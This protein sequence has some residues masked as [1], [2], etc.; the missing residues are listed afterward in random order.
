M[1]R[2][3]LFV[4]LA[5]S[6]AANAWLLLR[7][8]RPATAPAVVRSAAAPQPATPAA[9]TSIAPPLA[10]SG[11][12]PATEAELGDL[13]RQLESLGL[14]REVVQAAVA[15][16]LQRSFQKRRAEILGN[17]G[18]DEYWRNPVQPHDPAV[19]AALRDLEREQ[20]R[21]FRAL[22]GNELEF[23]ET[24]AKRQFG[25]LAPAKVEQLK[26]IFADYAD[27]EE[28][29]FT[30]VPDRNAASVRA[31]SDLLARE[32]RADM[33]R[34]LTPEELL[35]YDLRNSP[36]AHRLRGRLG[37]FAATEDEFR[38][39]YPAFK[40]ASEANAALNAPQ[41]INAAE[42]RRVREE[43]DR[44]L[45]DEL[46]RVLGEARYLEF[47][48]ANDHELRQTRAFTANLNLPPQVATEVIAIQR[49]FAPKLGAID[50]DRDLTPNQRDARASDL[51]LEARDRLIRIL[52]P[53]GF[54]AYKRQGGGWLGA[55]LNRTPPTPTP[56]P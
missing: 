29:L 32:K 12:G 47:K 44:R 24:A 54:E 49:E 30:G 45:D 16:V 37:Q 33:E 15:V 55:A 8:T 5:A 43:T 34:L 21:Q 13:R 22:V 50:R 26:K 18:P 7:P 46:R 1:H 6:L 14:P 27:L 23:D 4:L 53:A 42:A 17:P 3:L 25:G 19:Q 52:G 9:T 41:R 11:Q 40:A 36:G 51:G 28:Q 39:L 10:W 2:L 31:R 48:D 56:A 35:N 20:H 38:T